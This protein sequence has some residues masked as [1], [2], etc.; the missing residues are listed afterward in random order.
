MRDLLSGYECRVSSD[1]IIN[2]T[3]PW[4]DRL[5][6]AS[7]IHTAAPMIG[8]VR[9]SH[10]V[11]PRPPGA[12]DFP[13]YTEAADGRPIFVIPWNDQLLVGTTEVPDS[14]DPGRATPSFEEIGYLLT[15]LGSVLPG[16]AASSNDIRCAFSGIRPLPFAP[17]ATTSAITRRHV[18]HDHSG[19]GMPGMLSLIGGGRP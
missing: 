14:G 4:A 11:L 13:V 15:S 6:A 12:L 7:Q 1:W 8:G 18:L 3:G 2:A 9:G 17:G 5:C 19:D 16:L 10:I